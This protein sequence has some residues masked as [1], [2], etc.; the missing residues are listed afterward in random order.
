MAFDALMACAVTYE[1]RSRIIG[2]KVEKVFQPAADEII[3]LCHV[4]R[5]TVQLLFSADPSGARV[6]L[7]ASAREN[8]KTPPMLC[9]QL[10]KHLTG[11]VVSDV[12]MLGFDRVIE[13]T[14]NAYD[15]LGFPCRK[16]LTTE[17]MGKYSNV[18]FSEVTDDKKKILGVLRPVDFT[19]STR[20]Q[21]LPGMTYELPPAQDKRDPMNETESGFVSALTEYPR[22]RTPDRF[23]VDTYLGISPL[24]AREI[25]ANAG[26]ADT[27]GDCSPRMMFSAFSDMLGKVRRNDYAPTIAVIDGV[28]REYTFTDIRQ[29]GESATLIHPSSFEEMFDTFY[30]ERER[31]AAMKARAHDI[32]AVV[33]GAIHKLT[34]KLPLLEQELKECDEADKFKRYGDL[35]TAS[36]YAITKKAAFCDVIDYWSETLE[37]VRIPLDIRMTASQNAAAYYKK[38]NKLKTARSILTDQIAAARRDL[39]Y[40]DTVAT[41]LAF[42]ENETDLSEIRYELSENGYSRLSARNPR[43]SQKITAQPL[44]FVTSTGREVLVGK[45][46]KQNDNLTHRLAEKN[47]W[48]FHVKGA[49]GSHVIMRCAPDE[50]PPASDFTQAAA[51]AAYYS[52]E[53]TSEIVAVDYTLAKNVKK[54]V[55]AASGFVIYHTNYSAFVTPALPGEGKR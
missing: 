38:Y 54:P 18:I 13:V 48:W 22:E 20:R 53:R 52:S 43:M 25:C 15:D 29:Y 1:M 46:N 3:L 19:T 21:V 44:R 4:G 12:G 32:D 55:G 41:S 35:I 14:F 7:T 24:I 36:S 50:D 2:A 40:L 51:L 37:T 30:G 45:N 17:I 49:A 10:R 42:A 28:P 16:C 6:S 47:D 27:V 5:E 8:P 34:K 11:A 23:I 39:E 33:S 31:V 26:M 9:M